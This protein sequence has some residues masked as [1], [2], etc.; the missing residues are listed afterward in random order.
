[1][2]RKGISLITLIIT[3]VVVIIL[4]AAVI[5]TLGNNNPVNS[6]KLASLLKSKE[7]M[8][9][10]I[11][12][13]VTNKISDT[14]GQTTVKSVVT[15]LAD[16]EIVDDS[17]LPMDITKDGENLKLYKVDPDDYKNNFGVQL[18]NTPST[19]SKWYVD[20]KGRM[21]L[22][23][24]FIENVPEFMKDDET[25]LNKSVESFVIV[26]GQE[27][28]ESI[29]ESVEIELPSEAV[30]IGE[31]KKL[32]V[33][34]SN[35]K[36]LSYCKWV[37]NN[38]SDKLGTEDENVY[39]YTLES[40]NAEISLANITKVGNYYLHML[41]VTSTSKVEKISSRIVVEK[42]P[43][44]WDGTVATSF[45][46]G[47]GTEL[48]PYIIETAE[49]LAYLASLTTDQAGK[50]FKL[51]NDID[52]NNILWTPIGYSNNKLTVFSGIFDG[53]NNKIHNLKIQ[54]S[55]NTFNGLFA[56]TKG[57][58]KN[59][60]IESGSVSSTTSSNDVGGIL[61]SAIENSQIINCYNKATISGNKAG[62][63]TGYVY[64]NA[65]IDSCYNLGNITATGTNSAGGIVGHIDSTGA[66][67]S[68]CYNMG[69]ITSSSYRAAGIVGNASTT[70]TIYNCY[71]VGVVETKSGK[72]GQIAGYVY[73]TSASC[74]WDY[75]SGLYYYN[76]VPTMQYAFGVCS[77]DSGSGVIALSKTKA[78][79]QESYS[80]LDFLLKNDVLCF[81]LSNCPKYI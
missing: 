59:L 60:G 17:E 48:D 13:V 49:Q 43:D 14:L 39:E 42:K 24:G 5:L 54:D 67:I 41:I 37:I 19:N 32:S 33:N 58:I 27:L 68:N 80:K 57:T 51:V 44:V 15:E 63:I 53:D 69:D 74:L 18:S 61:G 66:K 65:T 11:K 10:C 35:V 12:L 9:E 3:I 79:T 47:S 26:T 45:A 81:A 1:M 20:E 16:T 75:I 72:S 4:A 73:Y 64:A 46:S 56:R 40:N 78:L 25:T 36:N 2:K 21:F 71:N 6:S 28:E 23:Y 8:E 22:V 7:T 30:G 31:D 34:V 55:T 77:Y 38:S 52:L 62:G 70:C 29:I 76:P 50:Y